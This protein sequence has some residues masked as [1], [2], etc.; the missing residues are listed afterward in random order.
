CERVLRFIAWY[1]MHTGVPLELALRACRR[2][3][4]SLHLPES[5]TV[6]ELTDNLDNARVGFEA[7][8]NNVVDGQ[9][10]ALSMQGAPIDTLV[11]ELVALD[12][13]KGK[14]FFF[15]LDEYENFEDYQQTVVN[16]LIKHSGTL[17]SFKV[18]VRELGLRRRT[19]VNVNEQLI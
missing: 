4:T 17:Y 12:E 8:I 1:E 5:G 16:S 7:Y 2:V 14:H 13:L 10:P 6:I 19:T 3:A 11:E 18:G 15:L 9:R